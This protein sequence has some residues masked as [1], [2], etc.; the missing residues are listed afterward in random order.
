MATMAAIRQALAGAIML[1]TLSRGRG[2]HGGS[3]GLIWNV[4]SQKKTQIG[5][6]H[7]SPNGPAE[8][9]TASA[10]TQIPAKLEPGKELTY[11]EIANI[12]KK[13]W[14]EL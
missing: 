4:H 11:V 6:E 7:L 10:I 2:T 14:T 13:F 1:I 5:V 12:Y 8:A 3:Q 9:S